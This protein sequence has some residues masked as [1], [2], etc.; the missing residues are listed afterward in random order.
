MKFDVT[1]MRMGTITVEAKTE[2][3]AVLEANKN[4]RTDDVLWD[5]EFEALTADVSE[6][7]DEEEP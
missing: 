6:K 3:E 7:E 5:A 1:V 2:E 4:G